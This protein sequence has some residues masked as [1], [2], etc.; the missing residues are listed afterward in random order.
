MIPRFRFILLQIAL[1]VATGV[2]LRF[3]VD[4]HPVWW[5]VWLAPVPLLLIAIQFRPRDARW[6]VALAA[7]IG[8]SCNFHYYRLVMP[9]PFVILAVVAQA[10]L[11]NFLIFASRRVIVRYRAWWTVLAY[12]VF[13]V[14]AD[15][16]MA[17]LLPD[18]NWGS[19]A[20]SQADRLPIVQ[21][22]SLF[23]TA[24]LLFLI[25]LVPS[26]LAVTIAYG[27]RLRHCWI[28]Y[29]LTAIL[30][31]ASLI[32][33]YA[34]LQKPATGVETTFGIVSIDD[35]IGVKA[36]L[37][38]AG[39]ILQGYDNRIAEVAA[40]GAQV[41]VLPEKI[42][43]L[44]PS[45]AVEWQQH[46][47]ALARQNRV[48]LEVG[49]GI[50]DGKNPTNWAWLFTPEGLL[51]A[52]Y[53]KHHMAPPERRAHYLSG[54]SYTVATIAG[55][56]C[57]LAICK[58]MHFAALGR[59]YGQRHAAVM[60][61]PAWDFAYLDGWMEARTTVLR[62]VENG[63][64]IVR[65]SRE[66]LLT[67]SDPYGRILAEVPSSEM[68]GRSLLARVTIANPLPTLYTR[69]GN[70]FGWL[71]A[72]AAVLLFALSRAPEKLSH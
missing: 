50:D 34:R 33:G 10:L 56:S 20:Y 15:T 39:T 37:S 26:V 17:A 25:A 59:A 30:L 44:A 43:I 21:I 48:W 38:Y 12:P 5:L 61:V 9:L 2:L 55:Q 52:S 70:L 3:V 22:A 62:G 16:L 45:R 23:G 27:R 64:I 68:P 31:A 49:V 8:T 53:E 32:F 35:P 54:T 14:A 40:E 36:S 58:D 47:S 13:C 11:W 4:L 28:A 24:G 66:G 19:L 29:T 67:A 1:A 42:A 63:Y 6:M 7:V 57:G 41:V 51:A 60:L 46:F 72:A 65:A 18:G 71:S 69:I